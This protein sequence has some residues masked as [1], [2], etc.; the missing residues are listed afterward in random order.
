[1]FTLLYSFISPEHRRSCG[2]ELESDSSGISEGDKEN[3]ISWQQRSKSLDVLAD[4][5]ENKSLPQ[6]DGHVAKKVSN[7]TSL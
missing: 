5:R 4:E 1:M 2:D 7:K 3:K 6:H